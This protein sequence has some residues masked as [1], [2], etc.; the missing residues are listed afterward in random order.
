M[1]QRKRLGGRNHSRCKLGEGNKEGV[2]DSKRTE[3]GQPV[4]SFECKGT[5][6]GNQSPDRNHEEEQ[7]P[8]DR[9]VVVQAYGVPET[10]SLKR[11]AE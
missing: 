6:G 4:D 7:R 2:R 1:I 11:R 10:P 5:R 9:A 8:S 3:S